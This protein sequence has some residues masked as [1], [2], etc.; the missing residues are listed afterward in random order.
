MEPVRSS[1]KNMRGLTYQMVSEYK[2]FIEQVHEWEKTRE[3]E[4]LNFTV[5]NLIPKPSE[6]KALHTIALKLLEFYTYTDIKET[7]MEL[8]KNS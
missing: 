1:T 8:A 5:D 4:F 7:I 6:S 2:R 3:K